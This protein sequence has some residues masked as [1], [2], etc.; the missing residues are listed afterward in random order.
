L[1]EKIYSLKISKKANIVLIDLILSEFLMEYKGNLVKYLFETKYD[2]KFNQLKKS[3]KFL[4]DNSYV[5][6]LDRRL[7]IREELTLLKFTRLIDTNIQLFCQIFSW[8]SDQVYTNVIL[9]YNQEG[10]NKN[11]VY[12]LRFIHK[13]LALNEIDSE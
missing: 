9:N 5:K 13:F 2:S 10:L 4:N 11:S 6:N 8:L 3:S 1:I 7:M 12:D